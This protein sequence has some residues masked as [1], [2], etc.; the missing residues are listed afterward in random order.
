MLNQ[1]TSFAHHSTNISPQETNATGNLLYQAHSIISGT[2]KN[3]QDI[4]IEGV[5]ITFADA[6]RDSV[7]NVAVRGDY[8]YLAGNYFRVMDISNPEN[9]VSSS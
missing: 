4:G 9:P 6:S 7:R 2:V 1:L 3:E 5:T 8:A